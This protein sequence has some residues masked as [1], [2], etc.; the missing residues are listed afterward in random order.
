MAKMSLMVPVEE[1]HIGHFIADL[2]GQRRRIESDIRD[3]ILLADLQGIKNLVE[4]VL[5]RLEQNHSTLVSLQSVFYFDTGRKITVTGLN[6]FRTYYDNS[7][8]LSIGVVISLAVLIDFP[9]RDLPEKQ[10]LRISVFSD[11]AKRDVIRA[12]SKD[13]RS[14]L[15]YAIDA[16]SVTWGEDLSNYIGNQL[17]TF[18]RT[19]LFSKLAYFSE[20]S[21][22]IAALGSFFTTVI[23]LFTLQGSAVKLPRQERDL[24]LSAMSSSSDIADIAGLNAKMNAVIRALT[25]IG[26]DNADRWPATLALVAFIAAFI[27]WISS[28]FFGRLKYVA[29]NE[30]TQIKMRKAVALRS[31]VKW[32]VLVSLV[33]GIVSGVLA[34]RVD[35]VIFGP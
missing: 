21:L 19:D 8:E 13:K 35:R 7:P 9:G 31:S 2:L 23:M 27:V 10:D 5:Q 18:T 11:F 24:L 29:L 25:D 28:N 3:S 30:H 20:N 22:V 34:T 1:S 26:Y 32:A 16:T 14:K 33:V 6:E 15:E 17:R 12:R 4:V